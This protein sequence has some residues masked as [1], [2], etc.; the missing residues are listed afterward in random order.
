MM[1]TTHTWRVLS[2][3]ILRIAGLFAATTAILASLSFS[4]MPAK[5]ATSNVIYVTAYGA[6]GDGVTNDSAA[7]QAAIKAGPTPRRVIF[8]AGTYVFTDIWV[9]SDT[10][11]VFESGAKGISPLGSTSTNF[12]FGV[13]GSS[14]AHVSNVSLQGGTFEGRPTTGGV[15]LTKYADYLTVSRV[16]STNCWR[17]VGT[18]LSSHIVI[19][20]C[21][22]NNAW[23]AFAISK[24]SYVEITRCATHGTQRDG[25]N[26]IYGSRFV[27]ATANTIDNY[28]FEATDGIGGIQM[29]GSTDGTITGN[30]ITRGNHNAAGIRIRDAERFWVAD[31]Y[32]VSPGSSG[33]QVHRVGDFLPLQGGDGTF[34]RNTV[35]GARLRGIDVP[36]PLT[37]PVRVV[38]NT[39]RS[40]SSV[41]AVSAGAGIMVASPGSIVVGNAIQD[42]TG[43]GIEAQGSGQLVAWNA[44]RNPMYVNFGPNTGIFAK[45][46]SLAVGYNEIVDT[47]KHMNSGILLYTASSAY[48]PGNVIVG[49]TKTARDIRGTVLPYV[50]SDRTPPVVSRT[51]TVS[52][53]GG[54]VVEFSA[55]DTQTPVAAVRTFLDGRQSGLVPGARIA[56]SVPATGAHV[57]ECE[58][59]D[60][61]GNVGRST[62]YL[63]G[64][65][66]GLTGVSITPTAAVPYAGVVTIAGQLAGP[67]GAPLTGM[68]V[69][70]QRWDTTWQ[71]WVSTGTSAAVDVA[72]GWKLAATAVVN[73]R[74]RAR[75][76]GT[77]DV[78]YPVASGAF[79]VRVIPQISRPIGPSTAYRGKWYTYYG[80]LVPRHAAGSKPIRLYFY[81][82]ESGKW[83]LRKTA[84]ATVSNITG[85]SRYSVP[86]A[87]SL[88]G[89]WRVRAVHPE[90]CHASW[91]SSY[92]YFRVP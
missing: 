7:I 45:G 86:V 32:I 70:L 22:A 69:E 92:R 26:F 61:A 91:A 90:S 50:L 5:A 68:R 48:L 71:R 72:G 4:A 56:A 1:P 40:T 73:V 74:Y 82:S 39:V 81:R 63:G 25:I 44:V 21:V 37:K 12:F 58:A 53:A 36:Y 54:T 6:K 57:I 3:R 35:V 8:P 27:T 20:D 65:F 59:I 76:A 51:V 15:V 52:P 60:R 42:S 41:S 24:S 46:T 17:N 67:T 34:F 11:I 88:A 31:N 19:S 16:T 14:T 64:Q 66:A 43:A 79:D 47:L 78:Y 30:T 29:Y 9:T 10:E 62:V 28:M 18:D 2:P 33:L 85:G 23:I 80:T 84:Y 55:V 77:A 13:V 83:V 89:S 38:A 75:F 49:Y 87:L